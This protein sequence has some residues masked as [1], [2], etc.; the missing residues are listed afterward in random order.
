MKVVEFEKM[1][2]S[3]P[4]KDGETQEIVRDRLA[5]A[6]SSTMGKGTI[7]SCSM[8][9]VEYEDQNEG[10]KQMLKRAAIVVDAQND[11]IT[12]VLGT[13]EAVEAIPFIK[14]FLSSFYGN[15]NKIFYTRDSHD[16]NYLNTQEG[17]KLPIE[18]CIL[19]SKGWTIA[20]DASFP[21][22]DQVKYLN[23]DQFSYNDWE[24]EHLDEYYEIFIMGFCTDICVIANALTI[25][26]LYPELP[27]TVVSNCCAGTTP[28]KH[29][30]ALNVMKSCQINVI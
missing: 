13:K 16:T 28:E 3:V 15:E 25:K 22:S 23:K 17:R 14:N 6:I 7:M 2:I 8:K 26:A 20:D 5:E 12:G 19:G 11:F 4:L 29:K 10:E 21:E 18:H 27:I 9:T 1:R 30:A 24:S